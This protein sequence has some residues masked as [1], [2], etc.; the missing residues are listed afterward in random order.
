VDVQ[1]VLNINSRTLYRM[2][3][4]GNVPAVRVGRQWRFRQSDL[5]EW[6]ELQRPHAEPPKRTFRGLPDNPP[7]NQGVE[8]SLRRILLADRDR[9][10]LDHLGG[11]L[12]S[13]G[14]AMEVASDAT[15]ALAMLSGQRYG[16]LITEI[17]TREL[18]GLSL[19]ADARRHQPGLPAIVITANSTES[20]AIAAANL[21]VAGYFTKPL[22]MSR[23]MAAVLAALGE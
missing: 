8:A 21:G 11:A 12:A 2:A 1:R 22:V 23:V 15:A 19:I 6:L 4:E 14:F 17:N 3:K 9:R 7:P 10:T 5:E 16:L 18:D 20:A 13:T